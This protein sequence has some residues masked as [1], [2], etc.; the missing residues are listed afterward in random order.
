[1]LIAATLE[2][3]LT[4]ASVVKLCDTVDGGVTA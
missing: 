2:D 3:A 4:T 1:M